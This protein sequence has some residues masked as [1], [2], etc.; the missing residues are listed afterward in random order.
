MKK[1]EN[2]ISLGYFCSVALELQR[3]GLRSCSSPFD[4]CISEWSG[5]SYY[6]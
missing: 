4:W 1:Y 2:F 3:L 5:E 6:R